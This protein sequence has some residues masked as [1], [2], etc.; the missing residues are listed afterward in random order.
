[1]MICRTYKAFYA[2]EL[3]GVLAQIALI[4]LD[5]RSRHA[6]TKLGRYNKMADIAAKG[7]GDF[8]LE[9]LH[10]RSRSQS[11]SQLVD[12]PGDGS[13]NNHAHSHAHSQDSVPYGVVD[14]HDPHARL[15]DPAAVRMDDFRNNTST[16]GYTAY[17]PPPPPQTA[18]ANSGYGY[19]P[20]R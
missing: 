11:Q 1:M 16:S 13:S 15:R 6:Q 9:D 3:F 7:G 8:K 2:F 14:Y 20:Q 19:G 18:Y 12:E 5:A 17:A 10:N 4:V